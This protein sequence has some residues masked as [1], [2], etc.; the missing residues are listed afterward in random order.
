MLLVL[1]SFKYFKYYERHYN[2]FFFTN[3]LGLHILFGI[4]IIH[5]IARKKKKTISCCIYCI[6]ELRVLKFKIIT[7]LIFGGIQ[8][9]NE[10]ITVN[11]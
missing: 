3:S 10:I 4:I 11:F 2:F 7:L 9:E 8:S 1:C 5:V 6:S